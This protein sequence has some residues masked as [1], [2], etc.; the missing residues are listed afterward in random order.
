MIQLEKATQRSMNIKRGYQYIYQKNIK[1]N[2]MLIRR[3]T[4][5]K[6]LYPRTTCVLVNINISLIKQDTKK[7]SL[8]LAELF[9]EWVLDCMLC[10]V[11]F[12]F[13][14]YVWCT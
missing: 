11:F 3:K 14:V 7:K 4:R 5:N 2:P 1:E 13:L 12:F 10:I 6:K 8:L 9:F